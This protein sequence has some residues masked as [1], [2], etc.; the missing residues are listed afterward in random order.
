MDN[1]SFCD[2]LLHFINNMYGPITK[3]TYDQAVACSSEQCYNH[4]QCV[5][6][7]EGLALHKVRGV[8]VRDEKR[9]GEGE[10]ERGE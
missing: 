6:K 9:E 4:G 3:S 8:K 5:D 2:S 1:K 10:E 7:S